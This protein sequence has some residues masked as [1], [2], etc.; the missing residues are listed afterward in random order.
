MSL[1]NHWCVLFMLTNSTHSIKVL[2]SLIYCHPR[3]LKCGLIINPWGP[4]SCWWSNCPY[5]SSFLHMRTCIRGK[6]VPPCCSSCTIVTISKHG[7]V[8][9][10][11]VG[12]V[13][14][15]IDSLLHGVAIFQIRLRP[16]ARHALSNDSY[17]L[18][19]LEAYE[20]FFLPMRISI[21]MDAIFTAHIHYP[22]H[23]R[24]VRVTVIYAIYT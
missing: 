7:F 8:R 5:G 12:V 19:F 16:L 22:L 4:Q 6:L 14:S 9:W 11:D 13:Y 3:C 20:Y 1:Q 10:T 23:S 21:I 18:P 17:C 2:S 24:I 15:L